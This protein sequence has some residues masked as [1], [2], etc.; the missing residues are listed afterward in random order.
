MTIKFAPDNSFAIIYGEGG[1]AD[2]AL[3]KYTVPG[4]RVS[5]RVIGES[6]ALDLTRSGNDLEARMGGA[7][8]R[9]TRQ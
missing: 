2:T 3:G 6:E 1:R 5:L 8:I 4:E 7:A 9:F